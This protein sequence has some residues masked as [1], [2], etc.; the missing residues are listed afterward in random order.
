MSNK[1]LNKLSV[2]IPVYN[3][4][5]YIE[6]CVESVVAQ[7]YTNIEIILVDDGSK[8]KSSNI[9]DEL[10]KKY[11]CVRVIHKSNGGLSDARNVGINE[12]SGEYIVF[13][14]GDDFI[15][16]NMLSA[17]MKFCN[18]NQYDVVGC[19]HKDDYDG[20]IIN[21]DREIISF[22]CRGVEAL[23]YLLEGKLI[24]GT[25]C[26]K[27]I[28]KNLLDNIRF[29]IG[30]TYEDVFFTTELLLKTKKAHFTTESYYHY[31][32]R[33][34][35]ITT[36]NYSDKNWD[37]I[38]GYKFAYDKIMEEAP[39][40]EKQV[41]FRLYWAHFIV[42]DRMLMSGIQEDQEKKKILISFIKCNFKEIISCKYFSKGRKLL[43]IALMINTDLYKFMLSRGLKRR[44]INK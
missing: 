8:D 32:H 42:L 19:H 41:L 10:S 7:D 3:I 33:T 34:N 37:I 20:N 12:A 39:H 27:I 25:A 31:W 5:K 17:L 13:I 22:D 29:P 43:A 28:K 21:S 23:E 1:L 18:T 2:I 11:D 4:E 26:A 15:E 38:E 36:E 35:S 9:C 14:D 24:P 6:R 16:Q 30:K 44:T 40:L